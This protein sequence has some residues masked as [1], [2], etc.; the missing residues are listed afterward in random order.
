MK[1]NAGKSKVIVLG[2]E[3]GLESEVCVEGVLLAHVSKFK[4][5]GYVLDKS[6]TDEEE[7]SRK[8]TSGRRVAGPIRSL[9]NARSLKVECARVLHE[10]FPMP[11]LTYG[12]ETMI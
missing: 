5:M 9:V 3:E 4:C 7:C 12:S 8:V 11:V 2:G 1:F 10:L 6:G